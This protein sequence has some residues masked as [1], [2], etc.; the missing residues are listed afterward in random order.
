MGSERKWVVW[1]VFVAV[2]VGTVEV[3]VLGKGTAE[4]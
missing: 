4:A 2:L 1:V 3:T